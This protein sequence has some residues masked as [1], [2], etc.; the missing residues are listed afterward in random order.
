M[1]SIED[2]HELIQEWMAQ[3]IS[4]VELA[5]TYAAIRMELDKQLPI[6]MDEFTGKG[7]KE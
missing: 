5:E 4:A 1:V 3:P 6:C 7:E 2:M